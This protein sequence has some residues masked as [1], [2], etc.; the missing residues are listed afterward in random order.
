[1]ARLELTKDFLDKCYPQSYKDLDFTEPVCSVKDGTDV[2]VETVRINRAVN[3]NG[4]QQSTHSSTIRGC[5]WSTPTGTVHEFSD[6]VFAR[7]S[8]NA[9]VRWWTQVM[10]DSRIC[11][12]AIW[13]LL[14]RV[15]MARADSIHITT[16]SCIQPFLLVEMGHNSLRSK[17]IGIEKRV[18]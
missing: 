15:L 8:E 3:S 9:I 2:L 6:P 13:R 5:T 18:R 1:M 4:K 16:Q 11:P 17:L 10:V 7:A 14:T 12:S